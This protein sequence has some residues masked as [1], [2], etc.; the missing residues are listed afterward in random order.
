MN[1]TGNHADLTNGQTVSG[2]EWIKQAIAEHEGPLVRYAQHFM[3]DLE[4]ARDVVQDTFIQLL[5][6]DRASVDGHL[7]P[8]LFKVC[9][10]RAIDICRKESRMKLTDAQVFDRETH[11]TPSPAS[12]AEDRETTQHLNSLIEN[13]DERQQEILRLKFQ[14]AMSYKE[15]ASVMGL[16]ATNVGFILHTAIQK[17]R[18]QASA[19]FRLDAS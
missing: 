17:V 12:V 6:C 4:R 16:T 14:N 19:K 2:R 1:N 10:N 13:L 5:K 11:E 15:I 7:R 8:W 18:K 3:G 9:R